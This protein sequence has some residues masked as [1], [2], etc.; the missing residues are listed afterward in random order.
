MSAYEIY[1]ALGSPYSLK[2][3][4]AMRAKR[5]PHTWT[6]MTVEDRARVMPH[7][8]A[9]VIPVIRM[10]DGTWTN[11]STPFLLSLEGEGRALVPV[12]PILRFVCLLIEDMADEWFMKAMFHYRW[13]YAEDAEW[14]ANWL[15]FDSLPNAGR[16]GVE[17]MA[18]TI[19]AR[20]I[21]R[22]ALVG[23]TPQ[24][25]PIIEAN[26]KRTCRAL[27]EMA[28][29]PTR[30]LFGDRISLADIALYG[31][32]KVM[33]VDPTPMAWLRANVPYLYR[34]LDLADDASGL[35][36]QWLP[37]ADALATGPVKALLAQAGDTY[38]PF[39]EANASALEAE[40]DTF[41]VMLEGQTY[42]QGA[43]KYQAKCLDTLRAGWKR[44]GGDGREVIRALIG[45]GAGILD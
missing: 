41:E 16:P 44:L 45:E 28:T 42:A 40:R 31:Q 12:D 17:K 10:P 36:G 13:A 18:A 38:L 29:G 4:A 27:D 34:W 14:C 39:L 35:E 19:R 23:C 32:L 7:V 26:W 25:A 3:R 5:L 24:T 8:K 2:V 6:G 33:S 9:Q 30:F 21:S 43:F 15:M 1:G 11:D 20:Q 22:M 37:P